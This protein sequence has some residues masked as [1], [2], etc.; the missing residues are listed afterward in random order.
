MRFLK[1]NIDGVFVVELER[2]H[3]ERGFFARAFSA[4]E[5]AECGLMSNVSQCNMSFNHRRGTL[6][7]LHMQRAPAPEAKLFR[8]IS[9]ATFH[10]AVDVRA[11]S[12]T[13]GSHV[14]V[15]LSSE[16]RTALYV[17]ELCAAGYQTL[18]PEAEVFYMTS[19]PYSPGCER[20]FRYDDPAF[21]IGW[22]LEVTAISDKDA[23]W[24]LIDVA[25]TRKELPNDH[26]R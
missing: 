5:F 26:P 14:G 16:S 23:N 17:P 20:G 13:Y 3:D 19:A 21:A 9:G 22:P 10:V 18:T 24:P 7:G 11:G 12:G 1:T 8:C 2:K 25:P 4:N 6:R 15:E